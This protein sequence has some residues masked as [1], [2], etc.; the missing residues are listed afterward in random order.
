MNATR[1]ASIVEALFAVVLAALAT[2][3]LAASV[4]TGS[5]ALALARGAGAQ[6]TATHD[7]LERLR[8]RSPGTTDDLV[9]TVPAVTR[10]CERTPGRGRPDALSVSGGWAALSRSHAFLVRSEYLP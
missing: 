6:A 2:G 7:G 3:I 5:R 1:G 10:H 8:R 9:G 4:F